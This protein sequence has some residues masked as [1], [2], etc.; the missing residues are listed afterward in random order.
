MSDRGLR[1]LLG[2]RTFLR[3]LEYFRR[4]AVNNVNINGTLATGSV[5]A[6]EAKPF[7]VA[8]ELTP[9]GIQ[10][11]CSCPVFAKNGQHCKH[12][13][14]LLI[15]VRDKARGEPARAAAPSAAPPRSVLLGSGA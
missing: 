9:D 6:N 13:A 3:G 1:R 12:V 5:R 14:A 2:A 7:A 4:K 11:R 8:V 15:C 10:S